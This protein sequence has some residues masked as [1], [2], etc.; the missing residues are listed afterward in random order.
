MDCWEE[1]EVEVDALGVSM[2]LDMKL[3]RYMHSHLC[4]RRKI[5]NKK[6]FFFI[7]FA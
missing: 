6:E 2:V 4:V 3:L 1:L 7:H 5:K